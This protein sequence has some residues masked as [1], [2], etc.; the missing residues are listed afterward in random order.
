MS[1]RDVVVT[2]ANSGFRPATAIELARA[3]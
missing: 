3:G 2:G 1:G